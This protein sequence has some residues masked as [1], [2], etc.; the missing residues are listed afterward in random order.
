MKKFIAVLMSIVLVMSLGLTA[1][2]AVSGENDVLKFD[3]NGEFKIFNICDI[4]DMYPLHA[5][6]KA[7]ITD[8]LKIHQPDLVVL[9]GDNTVA[10]KETKADAIKEICDM[11]VE[12]DT[13][14]TLVFGNH[15]D[16]QGVSREELL[17]MYQQFGGEYCLA[18]D[19]VPEL[20]GVGT[21]NLTVKS[22]DGSKI[23]YNLYM[24]DSNTY[25]RDAEGNH[26]GYDAVHEDQIEWY[27]SNS[28][29]VRAANGGETV[30]AMAFQHIIVQEI[31]DL[32]FYKSPIALGEATRNYDG[33]SYTIFPFVH[34]IKDGVL[35]EVPCPGY[36]NYG[37]FDAFVETGDVVAVFSGHDH[38]NSFTVEKDGVDIVNT[39]GCSF[40]SY[41]EPATRGIRMLTINEADTS[42]YKSEMLTVS[43]YVLGDGAYLTEFG[44]YSR[45]DA[46]LGAVEMI[47]FKLYFQLTDLIYILSGIKM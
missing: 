34:N 39:P 8:M 43:E 13:Y 17:A 14:F 42:V 45:M 30:Y 16:E 5:T 38:L 9:G 4:Q 46:I 11:F 22:S 40:E 27:K 29:E 26:L 33:L 2:A 41:G 7:F 28:A 44:E 21:H 18:Y 15:D 47:F 12:N 35:L 24:F 20:T 19:A 36:Y 37:Q 25:T 6:T 32:M 23:A 1:F 3:E 31:Y 10:S